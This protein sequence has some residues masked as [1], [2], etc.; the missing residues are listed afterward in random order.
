MK[1]LL[2]LVI[3]AALCSCQKDGDDVTPAFDPA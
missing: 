1:R 3:L 2:V